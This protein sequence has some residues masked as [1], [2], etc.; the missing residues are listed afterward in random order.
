[1]SM[2]DAK[3]MARKSIMVDSS[4]GMKKMHRGTAAGGD[5]EAQRRALEKDAKSGKVKDGFTTFNT[6]K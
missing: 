1:M 3:K 2:A 5:L 6:K 4:P